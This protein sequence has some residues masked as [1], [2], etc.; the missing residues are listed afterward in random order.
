MFDNIFVMDAETDGIYGNILS[1]AAKV[2]LDRKEVARFY[3]A[4]ETKIEDIKNDWVKENVFHYLKNA[5]Q[6]F[7]SESE[8]LEAF[9][10]FYDKH[11]NEEHKIDVLCDVPYPVE[12]NVFRKCIGYDKE[13]QK[14][15]PFP[16][17]DLES[18]LA[19]K[20]KG[21]NID[22]SELLNCTEHIRHDAMSDVDGIIHILYDILFP[23]SEPKAVKS[24]HTFY[25]PFEWKSNK[26]NSINAFA[27]SILN[28]EKLNWEETT[29]V[30]I[31][32]D[33]R[34][35]GKSKIENVFDEFS[36]KN[37]TDVDIKYY[38]TYQYFTPAARE[39]IFG[40]KKNYV[41]RFSYSIMEDSKYIINFNDEKNNSTSYELKLIGIH[42]VVFSTDVG[43]I[44][45]ET[46]NT[47]YTT[48]EQIKHINE[49]GR[50]VYAPFFIHSGDEVFCPLCAKSIELKISHNSDDNPKQILWTNDI[51]ESIFV[52]EFIKKILP[53]DDI[54]LLPVIDDR[55]FVS[56]FIQDSKEEIWNSIKE[57]KNN[58]NHLKSLYEFVFIDKHKD[59]S[60]QDSDM[61]KDLLNKALYTRWVDYGTL[62][63]ATYHSFVYITTATE[64]YV[65]E[66]PFRHIYSKIIQIVLMQHASLLAF[67]NKITT[68]S[69]GFKRS[70][71]LKMQKKY[72]EFLNLHYNVE[73]TCQEQG[74]D[75]Y[76]LLQKQ[77]FVVEENIHINNEIDQMSDYAN[78]NLDTHLSKIALAISI[79]SV[80]I[81]IIFNL[82]EKF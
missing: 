72:I 59:C 40:G 65:I 82:F 34:F 75:L 50:R 53:E 9:W 8:L 66:R 19:A 20:D 11:Y 74:H 21:Q 5:E 38:Q 37:D 68:V 69:K 58:E 31:N 51:N 73:I 26:G 71:I 79:A 23:S 55:M 10:Q 12:H 43:I 56:C 25:F 45:F 7:Y 64:E 42:L 49:L 27:N 47:N 39:G 16:V 24:L 22:R 81:T 57:Y 44:Y 41:R 29:Y 54:T 61:R 78:I 6:I 36:G 17:Y 4:V 15:S 60:C 2:I 28:S 52:P 18:F 3:G 70:E 63:A 35:D 77:L 13:R 30:S 32:Y 62:G 1:I 80:L 76:D 67:D 46:E 48:F 14:H 33:N